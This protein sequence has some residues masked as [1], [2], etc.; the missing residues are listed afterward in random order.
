MD[1]NVRRRVLVILLLVLAGVVVN[2]AVSWVAL[3]RIAPGGIAGTTPSRTEQAALRD[4]HLIGR[5]GDDLLFGSQDSRWLTTQRVVHGSSPDRHIDYTVIEVTSGWPFRCA[6]TTWIGAGGPSSIP[7]AM[8]VEA[9]PAH[10]WPA[11]YA[12]FPRRLFWLALFV[13]A[14]L[15]A[16]FAALPLVLV[17][18]L[19]CA[20]RLW[21]GLCPTCKYPIGT[22]GVCTECGC[23]VRS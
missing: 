3:S 2:V 9:E 16:A 22:S 11:P 19:L 14:I 17:R 15:Y 6:R 13:N 18:R 21:R 23:P 7:A 4:R 8:I 12:V 5:E 10:V 1:F 20:R